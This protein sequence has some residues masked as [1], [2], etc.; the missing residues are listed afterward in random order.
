MWPI[1]VLF[2]KDC[3]TWELQYCSPPNGENTLL[4]LICVTIF[5]KIDV[6]EH[7]SFLESLEW[8]KWE[9]HFFSLSNLEIRCQQH[10]TISYKFYESSEDNT[11]E[12]EKWERS[13]LNRKSRLHWEFGHLTSRI[14]SRCKKFI[15]GWVLR[16]FLKCEWHQHA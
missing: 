2:L 8:K 1:I 9:V 10:R 12:I 4:W 7:E 15:N 13:F 16:I 5:R 6:E 11:M 3:T 14:W